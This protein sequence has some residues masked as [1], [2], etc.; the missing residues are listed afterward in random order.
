MVQ[1]DAKA[2]RKCAL[3]RD[4]RYAQNAAAK[5]VRASA[6]REIDYDPENPDKLREFDTF[7]EAFEFDEARRMDGAGGRHAP[8]QAPPPRCCRLR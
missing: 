4:R 3:K 1:L 6:F 8:G 7:D 5:W 2:Q